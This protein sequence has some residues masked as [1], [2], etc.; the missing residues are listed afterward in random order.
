MNDV[1]TSLLVALLA[2]FALWLLII[3]YRT[4]HD[5]R[6]LGWFFPVSLF[7]LVHAWLVFKYWNG[8]L[9]AEVDPLRQVARFGVILVLL[10]LILQILLNRVVKK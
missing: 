4:R 2:W 6:M 1:Y 3:D 7:G 8:A 9:L 10:Q 5:K